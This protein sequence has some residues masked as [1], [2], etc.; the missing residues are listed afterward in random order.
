MAGN[1]FS[2]NHVTWFL[3]ETHQFPILLPLQGLPSRTA[4]RNLRKPSPSGN[5]ATPRTNF[6][7][8]M[9]QTTF[10][11]VQEEVTAIQV[12]NIDCTNLH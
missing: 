5:M 2:G 8:P 3:D 7:Q 12:G 11:I 10:E 1:M 9:Q 4:Y 6:W